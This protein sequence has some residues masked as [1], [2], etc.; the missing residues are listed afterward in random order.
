MDRSRLD[1]SN[2]AWRAIGKNRKAR[3]FIA[4][5]SL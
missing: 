4:S 5:G 1:P 2:W 3:S